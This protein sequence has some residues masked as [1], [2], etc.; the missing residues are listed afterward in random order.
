[1]SIAE[2]SC[3]FNDQERHS[4]RDE[5]QGSGRAG[6]GDPGLRRRI[7]GEFQEMPGL[8]ITLAQASR[9]FSLE[10][11]Q[12]ERV[13]GSLVEGGVLITDGHRFARADTGRRCM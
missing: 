10:P 2:A 3:I 6:A 4:M 11:A 7:T 9:L 12:C 8:V 1:M 5:H 13:L